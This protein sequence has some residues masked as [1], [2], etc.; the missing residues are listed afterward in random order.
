MPDTAARPAVVRCEACGLCYTSPRP[1][2]AAIER[3]YPEGYSAHRVRR[4]A[5]LSK[6]RTWRRRI[7]G[8]RLPERD[9]LAWHGEGRLL[10]FGCGGGS[11]LQR[12]HRQGW[13]VLG[14]D[15]SASVVQRIRDELGL[16]A[17]AGDLSAPELA[18]ARFDV[19]T[20][21]Q[22]LEH[23]HR[24]LEVLGQARRLL[25]PGG[26]LI[27][28]VPNIEGLPFRW[29][30]PAWFG[31]DLPRHLTHFSPGTLQAMLVRAGFQIEKAWMV[32]HSSWLERSA[33]RAQQQGY[34]SRWLRLLTWRPVCRLVTRY[35]L[36]T[37]QSDSI[38]ASATSPAER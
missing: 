36:L 30:G 20:M 2:A 27:V 18:A 7:L 37:R 12:M 23:V 16:P 32:P 31:L 26:K 10:D 29:F 19:I 3:F 9:G 38:A 11:F 21:W 14:V 6:L 5:P 8:S 15:V 22:S 13:Q 28:S 17:L 33:R 24:P 25:A 1:S 4:A 35:C 34:G